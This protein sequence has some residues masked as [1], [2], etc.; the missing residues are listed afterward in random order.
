MAAVF[1]SQRCDD[2]D[3]ERLNYG[4]SSTTLSLPPFPPFATS[5]LASYSEWCDHGVWMNNST[6]PSTSRSAWHD[7]RGAPLLAMDRPAVP[8]DADWDARDEIKRQRRLEA[9]KSGSNL[10]GSSCSRIAQ[11]DC[12]KIGDPSVEWHE[13]Q[14]TSLSNYDIAVPPF[15]RL[16]SA[17]R[18]FLYSRDADFRYRRNKRLFELLRNA[19]G[20]RSEFPG[21]HWDGSGPGAMTYAPPSSARHNDRDR[22]VDIT[23]PSVDET[24]IDATDEVCVLLKRPETSIRGFL[25][26]ARREA[27]AGWDFEPAEK[28]SKITSAFTSFLLHYNVLSEPE[29][30]DAFERAATI[31]RLAPS[32]LIEAKLLEE[33]L[34]RGDGWNRANWTVWGGTY[35]GVERGGFEK[36]VDSWSARPTTEGDDGGWTVDPIIDNRPDPVNRDDG[37]QKSKLS[38]I[39]LIHYIPYARR[40]IVAVLP[41]LPANQGPTYTSQC[42]RILTVPAPWTSEEKW[43]VHLP[44]LDDQASDDDADSSEFALDQ[45]Q[46]TIDEPDELLVWVECSSLPKGLIENDK[47][48]GMGLRGRWGL[49]GIQGDTGKHS[50]WWTRAPSLLA[51]MIMDPLHAT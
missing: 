9:N 31:A 6:L 23:D 48:V 13:P 12:W 5:T 41:P 51:E 3:N 46:S 2:Q 35:G 45:E 18:D 33:A 39:S 7:G 40:R 44:A 49:M 4:S 50:Q 27:E 26:L 36:E 20:L 19:F 25:A 21:K 10:T 42:Y 37:E 8:I 38:Q 32:N 47:L 28:L 1:I 17:T 15:S 16:L 22:T 11:E 29:L 43:R 14:G 30:K 24:R 34:A